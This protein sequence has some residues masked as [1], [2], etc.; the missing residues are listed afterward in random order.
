[1]PENKKNDLER[2]SNLRA[3]LVDNYASAILAFSV[4]VFVSH[5]L[6]PHEIG[7]FQLA[8]LLAFLVSTLRDFGL[9]E[10]VLQKKVLTRDGLASSLGINLMLSYGLGAILFA[11]SWPIG[12]WLKQP[13]VGEIVRLLCL[14]FVLMPFGAV[15]MA[16]LRR[17]LEFK[18]IMWVSLTSALAGAAITIFGVYKGWSYYSLAVGALVGSTITVIGANLVK[19]SEVPRIPQFH[20]LGE[21]FR[22]G[23]H[24]VSIY[25]LNAVAK[26]FPEQLIGR[27][28]NPSS[29][30]VYSRGGSLVEIFQQSVGRIS[31]G[32]TLPLLSDS[33]RRSNAGDQSRAAISTAIGLFT[34]FGW[35]AAVFLGIFAEPITIGLFGKQWYD[36]VPIGRIL[37][38]ALGVE[39]AWIFFKEALIAFGHIKMASGVQLKILLIRLGCFAIGVNWGLQGAAFGLAAAAVLCA[40]LVAHTFTKLELL[41]WKSIRGVCARSALAA[42]VIAAIALTVLIISGYNETKSLITGSAA[43]ATAAILCGVAWVVILRV[44]KHPT[45][46]TIENQFHRR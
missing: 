43:L 18:K 13:V 42:L 12:W 7:V 11:C 34:A 9:T 26:I 6:Q 28:F 45:W 27:M 35:S 41:D 44:T 1:M 24:A 46:Q 17:E 25:G 33:A 8:S 31:V 39:V 38:L 37:C 40:V 30:A 21:Q 15:I 19:P 20:S 10:Y 4:N 14:N 22:F 32:M 16:Y 29:V 36:S 23:L 3:A 5:R 2:K